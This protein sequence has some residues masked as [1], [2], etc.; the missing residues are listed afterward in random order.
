[1]QAQASV[2]R[3]PRLLDK[4]GKCSSDVSKKR[5]YST[6]VTWCYTDSTIVR[7]LRGLTLESGIGGRD[8]L[9]MASP[10]FQGATRRVRLLRF[11][12]EQVRAGRGDSLKELVIA[13]RNAGSLPISAK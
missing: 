9:R 2:A 3:E 4:C 8:G 1:V 13:E 6:L 7:P 11:L 5:S 12:V 10:G